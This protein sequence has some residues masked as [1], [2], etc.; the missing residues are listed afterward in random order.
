M[1]RFSL[2]STPVFVLFGIRALELLRKIHIDTHGPAAANAGN[3]GAVHD[4]DLSNDALTIYRLREGIERFFI[5]DI[6]NPAA[7]ATAQSELPLMWDIAVWPAAP[8]DGQASF[9]H[10]PGGGNVL[11]LDGHVT[12]VRYPGEFPICSTW[13]ETLTVLAAMFTP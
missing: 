12:F 1:L 3:W 9:N 5:T 11:Y 2:A 10:I 4:S 8:A 6:N 13:I 7:S